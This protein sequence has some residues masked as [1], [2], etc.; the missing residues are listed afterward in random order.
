MLYEVG[1]WQW[2]GTLLRVKWNLHESDM[3]SL[4]LE[5]RRLH[6]SPSAVCLVG[7][8]GLQEISNISA[9]FQSL[10]TYIALPWTPQG[11]EALKTCENFK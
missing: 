7:T 1:G 6:T 4:L 8:F 3:T 9:A 5:R 10:C 11:S 2:V